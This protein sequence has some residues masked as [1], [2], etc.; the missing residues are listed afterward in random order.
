MGSYYY[1]EEPSISHDSN[2]LTFQLT[3][4][5]SMKD[6][7]LRVLIIEDSEDDASLVLRALKKGGYNPVYERVETAAAMKKALKEKQWDIILCDY[8]LSKFNAP[9][10][11]A[12]L[13][14]ANIDIPLIVVTGNIG[15]E[16]AAECMRLG[17]KDYIINDNL[18][19][20]CPAIARE[21]EDAKVRNKQNHMENKLRR[22]EQRFQAFIEHSLDI[23]VMMNP[24]GI[25]TYLNP[26]I[27]RALGYKVEE[28]IGA[29]TLEVIHPDDLEY[30]ADKV[31]I[32][33]TDTNASVVQFEVRLRHKD[34]S[35]RTFEAVGSNLTHNNVVESVIVNYR[36]IT[37]RKQADE[38]LRESEI[39]Y[40]TLIETTDTG[41]VIIDQDGLVRDANSEYVRLTG[42]HDLSEIAGRS[43]IEWTAESGKEKNAEAVKA[44]FDKGYI[45]NLEID[46]V[47]AKGNIT[48]IEINATCMKIEGKTHTIT[49]C[50]DIT[51]RKR[52]EE[53]LKENEKQYRLLTEKMSDIVWIA[54]LNLQTNYI[55]PSI[56]NV[57]GFSQEERLRQKLD[58]QLTPH[59]LSFV[60]DVLSKELALEEQGNADPNRTL[61]MELEYYHK[62]G[63][64]RWMEL[65][66]SGIRNDQGVLTRIHGVSR[67]ISER[68]KAEEEISKLAAVVQFSSELVN[69]ATLDGKMIFL[70]KAGSKMLGIDPDKVG[71][72]SIMDVIPEPFEPTV[73]QEILP[74]LLAGNNWEGELQYRNI[75]TGVLT[76]VHVMTFT[77]K[78]TAKGIPLYLANVSRDITER[79]HTE[80]KLRNEEQRFRVLAEQSS[81][82]ILLINREKAIIYENPAVERILGMKT[83][84]RIGKNVLENLHPDDLH[85]VLRCVRCF[86]WR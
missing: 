69:L 81:D 73:R 3:G 77:I 66:I 7:S 25:V 52:A 23:I 26:A 16:K 38:A 11:I 29:N 74:T 20:L 28:R 54:D 61:K 31:A 80:E 13:K 41:Y 78:D 33:F 45:R 14:E 68:K 42:H 72:Y 71:D 39:K 64:T 12:V 4:S 60:L 22:E 35:W 65:V 8:S 37:E 10:A 5:R 75:R 30:L 40:R 83:E 86:D 55:S 50:R 1:N 59:S 2:E 53:D 46:Y 43:V 32:L 15:E 17:A 51:E 63:S 47:D 58:E 49:I 57:L 62:D 36:D 48:P 56:K 82:I 85:L 6:Q 76:D 79:K 67:D 84:D 44:C 34:G 24:E 18:S 27:E 19:R 70:N 9:S 21:L